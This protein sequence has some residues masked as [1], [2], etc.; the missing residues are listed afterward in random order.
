MT[1]YKSTAGRICLLLALL[2]VATALPAQK[3][4]TTAR[5]KKQKTTAVAK[6]SEAVVLP[7][8]S[9]IGKA[10]AGKIGQTVVDFFGSRVTY[11]DVTQQIYLWR[12]S[13]AVI[14]RRSGDT[15]E[16]LFLPYSLSGSTLTIGQFK[17][18][19]IKGGTALELQ[20]TT[21]NKEVRQGTLSGVSPLMM[22][23]ALYLHGKHLDNMT[24]QSDE[25]KRNALTCL[26]IAA[27]QGNAEA[28]QYLY[29]YYKKRADNGEVPALRYMLAYET[30]AGNYAE[31]MKYC[32]SLI[33]LYPTD[34]Q[35]LCVK[36]LLC[37]QT[38]KTSEAKK[39]YKKI[40]KLDEEF[41]ATSQHPFMKRMRG[42]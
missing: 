3:R 8:D 1:N 32:D 15:Q 41:Y 22:A 36:G 16:Y 24:I 29:E 35:W 2:M 42:E 5:K 12:D 13:I 17:Y 6:K 14:D 18:T 30:D 9:L 39:V 10:Y 11:G 28:R 19:T 33:S 4:K 40:K 26:N 21:E 31:A 34:A 25:D 27:E 7:I 23:N 20:K 38:D 37:L